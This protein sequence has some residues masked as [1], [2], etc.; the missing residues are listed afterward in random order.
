MFNLNIN[1]K[2]I[3]IIHKNNMAFYNMFVLIIIHDKLYYPITY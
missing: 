2:R 3:D 1:Y